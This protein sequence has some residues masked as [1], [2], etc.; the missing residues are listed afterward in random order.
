MKRFL[1]IALS[2]LMLLSLCAC[3]GSKDGVDDVNQEL[4]SKYST[5]DKFYAHVYDGIEVKDYGTWFQ[6]PLYDVVETGDRIQFYYAY[7]YE[8]EVE[9]GKKHY[10]D[11]K[12][13]LK[14][15]FGVDDDMTKRAGIFSYMIANGKHVQVMDY[16]G[17]DLL[18]IVI[19]VP[20]DFVK[21]EAVG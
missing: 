17:N 18:L 16:V 2:C 5:G 20:A 19:Q 12:N 8:D 7:D 10:S 11:Y 1:I 4:I 15:T 21:S 3:S 6:M 9:L 14:D 13:Y